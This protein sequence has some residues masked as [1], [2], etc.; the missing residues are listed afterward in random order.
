MIPSKAASCKQVIIYLK[1]LQNSTHHDITIKA[2]SPNQ[3]RN[4]EE[5]PEERAFGQ[6]IPREYHPKNEIIVRISWVK[7]LGLLVR[8]FFDERAGFVTRKLPGAPDAALP[9]Q[10]WRRRC[11]T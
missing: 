1:H 3:K 10:I 7:H 4:D 5:R 6:G 11:E 9:D 2:L 8:Y